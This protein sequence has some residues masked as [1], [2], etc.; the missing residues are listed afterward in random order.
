MRRPSELDVLVSAGELRPGLMHLLNASDD[1]SVLLAA[2]GLVAETTSTAALANEPWRGFSV[3]RSA[4]QW[5]LLLTSFQQLVD[6]LPQT[7]E[8]EQR[9]NAWLLAMSNKRMRFAFWTKAPLFS[10]MVSKPKSTLVLSEP[11]H[12]RL[13]A[14]SH[15]LR[16]ELNA[17][18]HERAR[19]W[20][21]ERFSEG[22]DVT[23][24]V[25]DCLRRS[26]AGELLDPADAYYKV[27]AEYFAATLQGLDTDVDD[28][29]LL[30]NLTE[31]QQEAY[32][33]AKGILNRFGG[34]FLADVVGLGKTFIAMA[35][36]SHLQR[37]YGEHAV[38]IAPPKV[39]PAWEELAKE[40]RVEVAFVSHGKLSDLDDVSDREVIVIDES[41]NFR[42]VATDRYAKVASWLRPNGA[43]SHRKILL[44]SATPQN[45]DPLDVKHQVQLFPDNYTRLPYLG[46][47]LDAWFKGV[48][49]GGSQLRELLQHIIVRRTRGY[50]RR[51]FPD[52][53][54]RKRLAPGR[55]EE[56]PIVFPQRLSGE[57]QCLRYSIAETYHGGVYEQVLATLSALRFPLFGLGAYISEQHAD[58]PRLRGQRS[59][60]TSIRGLYKVLLLKRLESSVH[61]FRLTLEGLIMRLERAR[62]L[63]KAGRVQV[64]AKRSAEEI[65]ENDDDDAELDV[66][67]EIF[68]VPASLFSAQLGR[69]IIEDLSRVSVVEAMIKNLGPD[70]DAKLARLRSYL[71][72]RSPE[73][74]RT[75]IFTQFADTAEYL[76]R[77][78]ENHHGRT[79]V[80]SGRVGGAL[81]AT[82]RFAPKANQVNVPEEDQIDLLIST[83]MLSEGV[84]LQDADTLINYDLHW[85]PVRLIQRAGRIDRIG[86]E[87]SEI[88]VASFLPER[89]LEAGLGLEEVLRRR[90]AEFV[91]VFGEDSQVLPGGE[92]LEL[93][94]IADAYSGKALS[95]AGE[96]DVFDGLSRHVDRILTLRRTDPERFARIVAIR[97]GRRAATTHGGK[98]VV[99]TRLGLYWSFW[100]VD[101]Q[102]LRELDTVSGLDL[103]FT[104]AE[105]AARG[106]TPEETVEQLTML[107]QVREAFE[108][109]AR[110][111]RAQRSQPRLSSA[112]LY[113]LSQLETYLD[114]C[115]ETRK[116]LVREIIDWLRSGQAQSV[117]ARRAK[118]W[119]R[120]QLSAEVVFT[121]CRALLAHLPKRTEELGDAEVV[122]ASF[123]AVPSL[124]PSVSK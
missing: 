99:A 121:E 52:A 105:S 34:V 119:K 96:A 79:V 33:Y 38:V 118:L 54:L 22:T 42:R 46:E 75:I 24:A 104:H 92:R 74:H 69:D 53:T 83:D 117:L 16:L 77:A 49:A 78:L 122:A 86:S 40:F 35:L 21:T 72:A 81:T 36:L 2:P 43:P 63:F 62:D 71:T 17:A 61:A 47:S 87:H 124:V 101:G 95:G 29:P 64:N 58:D 100:D 102:P 84:N 89:Q 48:R 19:A 3:Q 25:S 45:S 59:A 6:T 70:E 39:L 20:F 114:T 4:E 12:E 14:V 10:R 37:R 93:S 76:G 113:V 97:P 50:I 41:H 116:P 90:I 30:E 28:N 111:V 115:L 67:D 13:D 103:F 123:G 107:Q 110:T 11:L 80:V 26:W 18:E 91:A 51:A 68:E 5:A 73:L 57:D 98:S 120:E 7:P 106:V 32:H 31:F 65:S 109:A 56:V 82:R 108:P 9:I 66:F 94:D 44:L 112:E 15:E 60:G 8:W 85:N 55:Y 23:E 27:I 88:H 1:N